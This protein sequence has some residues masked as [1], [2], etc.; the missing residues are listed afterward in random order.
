[1]FSLFVCVWMCICA[2]VWVSVCINMYECVCLFFTLCM[3]CAKVAARHWVSSIT[4]YWFYFLICIYYTHTHTHIVACFLLNPELSYGIAF[5]CPITRSQI[6]TVV[7]SFLCECKDVKSET[8]ATSALY[9]TVTPQLPTS[10]ALWP[11]IPCAHQ[12]NHLKIKL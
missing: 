6:G 1:M 4:I 12:K 2:C 8:Y 9:S 10:L 7:F 5:L 3:G 11:Y